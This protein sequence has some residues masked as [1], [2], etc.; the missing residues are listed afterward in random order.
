MNATQ[1]FS[2]RVENYV[3]YRPRYPQAL[4]DTLR[5]E[6]G[7][8]P[9]LVVADIGSGTGFLAELFLRH[10]NRVYGIEPNPEMRQA[11]ARLL[12]GYP[13][14]T[15][16]E[17]AAEATSLP[18]GS[19]DFIAA[20]Q[21]FHWFDRPRARAEFAR[22]LRPGGWVALVWNNFDTGGS[23]FMAGY[24]G[25]LRTYGTDYAE[26]NHRL[27][28]RPVLEAFF[29]GPV[30][31]RT[32]PHRQE[33]DYDGLEGRLLS[34]SYAPGAD[35]PNYAPMLAALSALFAA[36]QS[37]GRVPFDYVAELYYARLAPNSLDSG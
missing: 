16:V 25:L 27:V 28:D 11:G 21:A 23:P 37:E 7:L 20:G 10:G 18:E 35:H 13:N 34:S 36:Y 12:A 1:R 24:E 22:I 32:F 31:L 5:A 2:S 17:A 19:V 15:S 3:L 33:F 9:E 14:F 4:I 26:V 8:T 30:E 29:G 6:C